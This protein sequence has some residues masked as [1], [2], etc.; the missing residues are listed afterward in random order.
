MRQKTKPSRQEILVA[1]KT[2]IQLR[3]SPG[4]DFAEEAEKLQ[5]QSAIEDLAS[6]GPRTELAVTRFK[7][8][9]MKAGQSVG[10]GLYKVAIDL[11]S[12]AAK[13]TLLGG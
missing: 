11:A 4:Y 3:A 8:L 7:Q 10:T 13:K 12:E 6:D 5:L 1:L 9:M 2:P